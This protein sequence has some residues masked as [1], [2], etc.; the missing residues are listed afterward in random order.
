MFSVGELERT[1]M[2]FIESFVFVFVHLERDQ[3][4]ISMLYVERRVHIF[5]PCRNGHTELHLI[6]K[7]NV[8]QS[9]GAVYRVRGEMYERGV[10]AL[11]VKKTHV[12]VGIN[13]S[14]CIFYVIFL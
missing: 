1:Q 2:F 8:A 10:F 13:V 6:R 14:L 4:D 7:K 11:H 5:E 3:L 12:I 9:Y